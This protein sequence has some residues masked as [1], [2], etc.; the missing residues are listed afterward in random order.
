MMYSHFERREE[1]N[2]FDSTTQPANW[3][4][5]SKKNR[6]IPH[7]WNFMNF[8]FRIAAASVELQH[9]FF[10]P[11]SFINCACAVDNEKIAHSRHVLNKNITQIEMSIRELKF[12]TTTCEC[13]FTHRIEN[14]NW[15]FRA[16]AGC[17]INSI[18]PANV[19]KL[20]VHFSQ[21]EWHQ[22]CATQRAA[23]VTAQFWTCHKKKAEHF[24]KSCN[25]I[26]PFIQQKNWLL[27]PTVIV[28]QTNIVVSNP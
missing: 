11:L 16:H 6:E 21:C 18:L 3:R 17:S 7:M 24:T 20:E 26:L 23:I 22:F 12:S 9:Y 27:L 4:V 2:Q 8:A 13:Q 25:S 10:Y 19:S 28:Q 1:E 5:S 15:C 14:L